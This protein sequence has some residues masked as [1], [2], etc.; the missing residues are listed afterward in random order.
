MC[1]VSYFGREA[2]GGKPVCRI[3]LIAAGECTITAKQAGDGEYE[4]A[5]A[6][7]SF[8]VLRVEKGEPA[9]GP[10]TL[11]GRILPSPRRGDLRE[12]QEG[13]QGL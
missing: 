5:E 7:L 4:A 12:L 13:G 6:R 10:T 8:A 11:P 2:T 1:N 3:T 9:T